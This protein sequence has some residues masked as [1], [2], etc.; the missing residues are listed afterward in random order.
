M[1]LGFLCVDIFLISVLVT[2][3][4][5]TSITKKTHQFVNFTKKTPKKRCVQ[6][7]NNI[8][9]V[10]K[11]FQMDLIRMGQIHFPGIIGHLVPSD[12]PQN[13]LIHTWAPLKMPDYSQ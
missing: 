5:S 6:C 7:C 2:S 3:K 11:I 13:P 10:N 12:C 1:G 8:W 4:S 9:P